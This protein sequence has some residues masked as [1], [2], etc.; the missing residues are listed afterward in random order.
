MNVIAWFRHY[1]LTYGW[2]NLI[3]PCFPFQSLFNVRNQ[4][5][6]STGEIWAFIWLSFS[7]FDPTSVYPSLLNI[8]LKKKQQQRNLSILY[9]KH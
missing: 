9:L 8:R 1:G 7:H 6:L 4:P 3:S 5:D 2:Y